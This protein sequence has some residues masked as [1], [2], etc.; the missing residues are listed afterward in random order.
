MFLGYF[1][2]GDTLKGLV[3]ARDASNVPTVA[4][5]L[6]TFRIYS[7]SG[8]MS[9][10]TGTTTAFDSGTVTGVYQLSKVLNQSDNYTRGQ[11][12]Q[13]RVAYAVSS[14]NRADLLTFIV[15]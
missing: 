9:N 6:P 10:G 3:Q 13:V 1:N 14:A 12:Y 11:L 8:I 4:D 5:A 7:A 2:L 15:V